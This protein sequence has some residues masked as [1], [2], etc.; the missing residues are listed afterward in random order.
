MPDTCCTAHKNRSCSEYSFTNEYA[1][2]F[3][4]IFNYP[5]TVAPSL[6]YAHVKSV[7]HKT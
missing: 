5:A 6:S 4:L 3:S 7:Y 2:K 1:K